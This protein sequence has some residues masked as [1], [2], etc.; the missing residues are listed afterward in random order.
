MKNWVFTFGGGKAEGTARDR[1]RLGG[2]GASLAEMA[3]LGLPVPPGFTISTEACRHYY[4][5]DRQLPDGLKREVEASLETLERLT[6]KSFG[7]KAK[8]LLVSVRSGSR[9]S[10]PGMLDTV[11]N[12]GLN[13]ESA[14][15]LAE[16]TGSLVFAYGTY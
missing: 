4:S 16:A 9:E 12:L 3:R 11:L 6:G 7:G 5:N 8:P 1:D 14:K 2:K 15:A 10:M 13:D